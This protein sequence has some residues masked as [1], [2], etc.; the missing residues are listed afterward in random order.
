MKTLSAVTLVAIVAFGS[1]DSFAA[2]ASSANSAH[3]ANQPLS[4]VLKSNAEVAKAFEADPALTTTNAAQELA[5]VL[6]AGQ[7]AYRWIKVVNAAR[8][9]GLKPLSYSDPSTT[10]SPSLAKP[11]IYNAEIAK[12]LYAEI[13]AEMPAAYRAIIEGNDP[14]PAVP[15]VNDV[16]FI[17]LGLKTT[18]AYDT[19]VRWIMMQDYLAYYEAQKISD[20]RGYYFLANLPQR[21]TQLKDFKTLPTA[22]QEQIHDWMVDLCLNNE[23][24][25]NPDTAACEADVHQAEA[26][27]TLIAYYTSKIDKAKELWD[28]FFV[29]F[30]D[31]VRTDLTWTAKDPNT[32][33]S[34]RQRRRRMEARRLE[35][36]T[37][38]YDSRSIAHTFATR[39]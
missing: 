17:H 23:D 31:S 37:G 20:V 11:K 22:L 24:P 12:N 7:R 2:G 39:V 26:A 4:L 19:G 28:S 30:D 5:S 34:A 27:Q 25:A 36:E 8:A 9:P 18:L 33:V 3:R 1:S 10:T 38:F 16:D 13:A 32:R 6:H 35:V 15:P 14:L 29:L 21:E